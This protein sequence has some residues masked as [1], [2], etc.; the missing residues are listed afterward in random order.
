M[1][2]KLSKSTTRITGVTGKEVRVAGL[3]EVPCKVAGKAVLHE[4][5]VAEIVEP[6]LLGIDFTRKHQAT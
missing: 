2:A 1:L 4:F 3:M 6:V 5:V